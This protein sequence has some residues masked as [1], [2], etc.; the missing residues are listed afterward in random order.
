M[1][2]VSGRNVGNYIA[3][4]TEKSHQTVGRNEVIGQKNKG[5]YFTFGGSI[6]GK[7]NQDSAL[8][9]Q[10]QLS[11]T[12]EILQTH[13]NSFAVQT[14]KNKTTGL[15]HPYDNENDF[16]SRFPVGFRGC[17]I[18]G[19]TYHFGSSSYPV[20]IN[21]KDE[22]KLKKSCGLINHIQKI[23]IRRGIL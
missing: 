4:G 6:I 3:G 12:E 22:S 23:K 10:I 21:S 18:C 2:K 17:F 16:T 5:N 15:D 1:I 14:K 19:A 8:Q 7:K 20:G 9:Y 13:K 11:L